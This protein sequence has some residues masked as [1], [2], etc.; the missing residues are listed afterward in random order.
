ICDLARARSACR[1]PHDGQLIALDEPP[2]PAPTFGVW[3]L[4]SGRPPPV[5]A[6]AQGGADLR[7]GVTN[8]STGCSPAR[9]WTE[10]NRSGAPHGGVDDRQVGTPTARMS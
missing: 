4:D 6:S 1:T 5:S 2:A 8:S 9:R 10:N 7:V 3:P